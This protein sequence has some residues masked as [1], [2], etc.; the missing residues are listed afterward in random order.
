[1]HSPFLQYFWRSTDKKSKA[2]GVIRVIKKN[3]SSLAAKTILKVIKKWDA[4][5]AGVGDWGSYSSCSLHESINSELLVV[6]SFAI[7]TSEFVSAA[8]MIYRALGGLKINL[9]FQ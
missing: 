5:I 4:A 2:I 6:P 7:M 1:M 8:N 9:L 3:Y